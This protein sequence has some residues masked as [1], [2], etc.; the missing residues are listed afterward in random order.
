MTTE[1][2]IIL[3]GKKYDYWREEDL[4]ADGVRFF[5]K[6]YQSA[7]NIKENVTQFLDM[8]HEMFSNRS[9]N[10]NDKIHKQRIG[11]LKRRITNFLKY[12]PRAKTIE[13]VQSKVYGF[14]LGL[15]GLSTLPGFGITNSHK[16]KP[17][18]NPEIQ[19]IY[20]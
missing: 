8:V 19:S 18:G 12:F 7:D 10:L 9:N 11:G 3:N 5:I 6:P 17:H 1:L 20:R 4:L 13:E 14:I 2:A 15:G 16:D